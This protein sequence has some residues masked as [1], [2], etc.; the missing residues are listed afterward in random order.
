VIVA[1]HSNVIRAIVVLLLLV[2]VLVVSCLMVLRFLF[3]GELSRFSSCVLGK[4]T[5]YGPG[6]MMNVGNDISRWSLL[7]TGSSKVLKRKGR[8]LRST[9][10][11]PPCCR[12]VIIESLKVVELHGDTGTSISWYIL[13][14][15]PHL[16]KQTK[17]N[18]FKYCLSDPF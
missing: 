17:F 12:N 15:F 11:C 18:R 1:S 8:A 6:F 3:F 16:E 4:V 2:G 13:T 7:K 5:Y 10:S 9:C 14:R